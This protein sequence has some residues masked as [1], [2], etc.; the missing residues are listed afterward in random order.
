MRRVVGSGEIPVEDRRQL[1]IADKIAGWNERDGI[2][3]SVEDLADGAAGNDAKPAVDPDLS[4]EE[5]LAEKERIGD[6][7]RWWRCSCD[8]VAGAVQIA[9]VTHV[10]HA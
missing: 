2:S 3:S 7:R 6:R 5:H 10:V 8:D 1:H 9:N 4:I